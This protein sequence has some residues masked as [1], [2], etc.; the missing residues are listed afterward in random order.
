[1]EIL[2][3]KRVLI[4]LFVLVAALSV[5]SVT[6]AQ[7]EPAETPAENACYAGGAWDGKCDWPT[8]AEDNWAWTCGWYYA[9]VI[10]GRISAAEAP[11]T[12]KFVAEQEPVDPVDPEV[13]A[14]QDD[15]YMF[16]V[17]IS[18]AIGYVYNISGVA[19]VLANDG[20]CS[21]VFVVSS[22][23]LSSSNLESYEVFSDGSIEVRFDSAPAYVT[24]SYETSDGQTADVR[25]DLFAFIVVD[26]VTCGMEG[27]WEICIEGDSYTL[28]RTNYSVTTYG[29]L[30][31]FSS[32]TDCFTEVMDVNSSAFMWATHTT[33][34]ALLPD[35]FMG[36]NRTVCY[37][38]VP[39]VP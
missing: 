6:L 13:C 37:T 10:D 32:S 28:L 19:G 31:Q 2:L 4:T 30:N 23:Q 8:E 16:D 27:D 38:A 17:E 24:F 11:E 15:I 18:R 14:P 25:I 3:M 29:T 21:T 9:R 26:P 39:V 35:N 36:D 34:G 12:C 5:A 22:Q 20:A 1:M 7:S 33:L